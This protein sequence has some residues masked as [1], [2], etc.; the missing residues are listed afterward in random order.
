M[1]FS[2]SRSLEQYIQSANL[3][4]QSLLFSLRRQYLD[5]PLTDAQ[6]IQPLPQPDRLLLEEPYFLRIDQI[7]SA[8]DGS[9]ENILTALQ[10]TLSACH[11]PNQYTLIFLITNDGINNHIYLG[12]RSHNYSIYPSIDFVENIG[13]FLQGNW[14]GTRVSVCGQNDPKFSK[15]VLQPLREEFRYGAA[16]TGIPSLKRSDHNDYPQ[17][18]DYFLRGFR[19]VPFTYMVV[20]EPMESGSTED[21][22]DSCRDLLGH[23][24]ALSKINQSLTE[25]ESSSQS[26]GVNFNSNEATSYSETKA[27]E[28]NN[29]KIKYKKS[30]LLKALGV[31]AAST[32]K[33]FTP[34]AF[35]SSL[36]AAL[37]SVGRSRPNQPRSITQSSS[38]TIGIGLSETSSLTQSV[39]E[40]FG[41]EYVNAHAQSA[42][43]QLQQYINRFE[44]SRSLGC[45]NVGVYLLAKRPDI[46]LQGGTQLKALLTGEHSAI[47]PIR[48][49][50][51]SKVWTTSV[52]SALNT[53]QQPCIGLVQVRPEGD[54]RKYTLLDQI[55]HPLGTSFSRLTTPLN[56]SSSKFQLKNILAVRIAITTAI[57]E[58]S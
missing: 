18:L 45:W 5:T 31:A 13:R 22:L 25:T 20:A 7:G 2:N 36:G 53:F 49:H 3:L 56:T 32:S 38:Q 35:A 9:C 44:K 8:V 1:N 28:E 50:D 26:Q 4:S 10:T 16:L 37:T 52:K 29:N 30:D 19:G 33:R 27:Q 54:D 6:F 43:A 21:I 40:A 57:T 47:E 46:C 15:E 41:Q 24:H 17:S 42:E 58:M 48:V 39:A 14:P 23:V 55:E 51:L 11:A 34:L 12:V